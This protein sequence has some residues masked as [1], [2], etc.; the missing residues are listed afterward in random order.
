VFQLVSSNGELTN[1]DPAGVRSNAP[2]TTQADADVV[3]ETKY[4][5][6]DTGMRTH[7]HTYTHTHTHTHT[8]S[9]THTL[10]QTHTGACVCLV[11]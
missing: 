10:K 11:W 5:N 3:H 2:M 7:I 4:V 6:T 1:D 9:N 8:H